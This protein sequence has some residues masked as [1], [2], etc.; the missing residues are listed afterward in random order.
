VIDLNEASITASII[1]SFTQQNEDLIKSIFQLIYYY[2]GALSRDEAW[3][4][5]HSERELAIEFLNGRF[6][7]AMDMIKK[8]VPVFI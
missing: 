7:E 3:S 8:Q 5:C 2:R 4:L 6:K 1:K